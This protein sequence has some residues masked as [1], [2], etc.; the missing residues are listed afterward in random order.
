MCY[1]VMFVVLIVYMVVGGKSRR[2]VDG[3]GM[4]TS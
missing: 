3:E 1:V 2:E 4:E